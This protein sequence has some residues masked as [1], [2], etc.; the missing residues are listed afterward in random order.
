MKK[1]KDNKEAVDNLRISYDKFFNEIQK[2]IVGQD[3]VIKQV[4]IA[5]LS[6]GHGLLVGVPGLAKTLLVNTIAQ[7]L[8]LE[9]KRIQFTPD[10]LPTDI[11]GNNIDAEPRL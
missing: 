5:I 7:I 8:G 10:L 1:Y 2:V 4:L 6:G 11:T 3:E 9:Y